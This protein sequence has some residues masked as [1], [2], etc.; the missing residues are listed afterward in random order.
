[1]DIENILRTIVR[2]ELERVLGGQEEQVKELP[3]TSP[4][5]DHSLITKDREHDRII[6]TA[7]EL[8]TAIGELCGK[9]ASLAKLAK[10]TLTSTGYERFSL[11]GDKEAQSVYDMMVGVLHA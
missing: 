3:A 1:M 11:V 10:D 9:D 4:A 6:S 7:S 5:Q 2:E 8:V